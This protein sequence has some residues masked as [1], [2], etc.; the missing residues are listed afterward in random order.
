MSEPINW[1][2]QAGESCAYCKEGLCQRMN[3][4]ME[5]GYSQRKASVVMSEES[6]GK[7]TPEVVRLIFN[8]AM[9]SN[10]TTPKNPKAKK[11][12]PKGGEEGDAGEARVEFAMRY[13]KMAVAQL[14]SICN[15]H[16]DRED[17]FNYVIEWINKN[18]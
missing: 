10:D 12:E 9:V 3:Q 6:G 14:E 16:P 7:W 15:G 4:L 18:R 2:F 17:A 5:D 11:A 8:R 1:V 13:A